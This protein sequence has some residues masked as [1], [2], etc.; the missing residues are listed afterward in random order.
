M[1]KWSRIW[2]GTPLGAA[3]LRAVDAAVR[4]ELLMRDSIPS[5]W[6]LL[7]LS[8][9]ERTLLDCKQEPRY[10][11]L[12]HHFPN[13]S[14]SSPDPAIIL[15]SRAVTS[16]SSCTRLSCCCFSGEI[17]NS[18]GDPLFQQL[19]RSITIPTATCITFED[20]A[21]TPLN[22]IGLPAEQTPAGTSN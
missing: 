11:R 13:S 7:R 15:V 6:D 5:S 19:R 14:H 18:E 20:T 16:S 17:K 2:N 10:Q 22:N 9:W 3:G 12:S 1:M 21:N 8:I 4:A